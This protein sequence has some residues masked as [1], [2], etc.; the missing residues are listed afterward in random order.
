VRALVVSRL[1]ADATTR[2]KLRALA[3][4]GCTIGAVVPASWR[5]GPGHPPRATEFG[6]DGAVRIFPV[7]VRGTD[8]DTAWES[9]GLKRALAEFRPDLVQVEEA[10]SSTVAAA[11][12]R[13]SSRL[14]FRVTVFSS[15][16]LPAPLPV[17]GRFRRDRVL[18]RAVGVIGGNR[19]ALGLLAQGR[20][21]P[22]LV[23]PQTGVSPP[24]AAA[25]RAPHDGLAI[26]FVGRLVPERG[27]D[28][29]FRACV[30]LSEPW[31]MHVAGSGPAQE[32]LE[33]LAERLG[34]AARVTWHGA[35]SRASLGGLWPRLDCAVLP[36]RTTPRWV[37][38]RGRTAL[39]AMAHGLP[40]IVSA[41]G[42]LPE[43]VGP[44]GRVVP[45]EGVDQLAEVLGEFARDPDGRRALG[46]EARRR[47]LAEYTDEAIAERTLAFWRTV[48]AGASP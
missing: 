26:G 2:G 10:P 31:A 3:G 30:R 35:L 24:L 16:S 11:V 34:I 43:V 25:D 39:E 47:V 1:Y 12:V 36:S 7:A 17:L 20:P 6:N 4:L 42:A 41:S 9:A 14:R 19:L 40:V 33:A 28:L 18:R 21:G 8:G 38:A 44:T 23:L 32:E 37:E 13:A 46:I 22:S 48:A 45:E 29:L 5:P 15:D 27:L